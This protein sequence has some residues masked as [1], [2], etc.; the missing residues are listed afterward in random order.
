MAPEIL[1]NDEIQVFKNLRLPVPEELILFNVFTKIFV[2][3]VQTV[4]LNNLTRSF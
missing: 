1:S 3:S 4:F 2:T